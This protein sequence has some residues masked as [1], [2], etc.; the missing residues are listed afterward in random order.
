MTDKSKSDAGRIRPLPDLR[1]AFSFLTRLP[2]GHGDRPLHRVAYLFP[3]VGAVVGSVGGAV[4]WTADGLGLGSWIAALLAVLAT[5]IVTGGLH[6][7]GL[8]D[9]ADGFGGGATPERRLE[10]MRDPR[11]GAFGVLALVFATGLKVAALAGAESALQAAAM[12]VAAHAGAR[13]CLPAVMWRMQTASVRG[14]AADAGKPDAVGAA[15]ALAIG[16]AAAVLLV[17]A[18]APAAVAAAAVIVWLLCRLA[19]RL[20]GGYNGDVLGAVEQGA[21]IGILLAAAAVFRGTT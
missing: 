8:A 4:Y 18:A 11:T 14:L 21:E 10:I 19:H 2:V 12:L 20:V 17:P 3:V 13:A 9:T 15:L 16:I 5:C 6:E 1:T 7:D